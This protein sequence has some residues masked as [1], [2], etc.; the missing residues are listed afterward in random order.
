M[1]TPQIA[2][3]DQDLGVG[4]ELH[5]SVISGTYVVAWDGLGLILH[6][7]TYMSRSI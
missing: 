6:M 2:A 7:F 1:T 4:E 5:Y 3:H